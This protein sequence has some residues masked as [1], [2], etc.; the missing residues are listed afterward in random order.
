MRV[1]KNTFHVIYNDTYDK[2]L[3][4]ILAKCGK[5]ADIQDILQETYTELYKTL[6][7]KETGYIRYPEAFMLRLAKSKVYQY[8]S[9]KER[10]AACIYV[11]NT[12]FEVDEA[13]TDNVAWEDN[14]I[15]KLTAGEVMEY[16]A[17]KD[18]LTRE[19]FYQHF[20]QDKTLKEIA[21]AYGVKESTVKNRLYRTLKELKGMKRF[22][23]IAAIL[24]L[25]A[26]LAKPVFMAFLEKKPVHY[27]VSAKSVS[28]NALS[29]MEE[30]SD[31]I[32]RVEKLNEIEPVIKYSQ[33]VVY[34]GYTFSEVVVKDV[35]KST[36]NVLEEGQKIR[37][38]EN[39]FYDEKNDIVYHVGGYNM[40]EQGKEY[41][42]FVTKHTYTDGT[43]YYVASGVNFGTISLEKDARMNV[44]STRT[45]EQVNPFDY[46]KPIWDAAIEKYIK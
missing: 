40:M 31:A 34:S 18:E 29:E 13:V 26:L 46:T 36:G 1:I 11:D 9:E 30:Y 6:L 37:I 28:F 38:L 20:F 32:I 10:Q 8:Y 44:F 4:Y 12:E 42:L 5:T 35:Y 17:G 24:L 2:V 22:A 45:G 19:I 7:Q 33:N 25:A 16:I 39:E 21:D 41:L 15:D 3:T 27:S 23:I 14:L 43:E